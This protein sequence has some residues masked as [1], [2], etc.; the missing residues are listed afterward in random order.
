MKMKMRL[1]T[2][3]ALVMSMVTFLLCGAMLIATTYAWFVHSTANT[4]N[5]ITA[6]YLYVDL[7]MDKQEDG[8]YVSIK[9]GQGDIFNERGNGANWE[10][11]MTKVVYLGIEN[12]ADTSTLA[13]K[14]SFLLEVEGDL[15]DALDYAIVPAAVYEGGLFDEAKQQTQM[16]AWD[17]VIAHPDVFHE[18]MSNSEL[19]P[20]KDKA[21]AVGEINY[22]AL[23]VHMDKNAGDEYQGKEVTIDV[24]VSATQMTSEN[25]AFGNQYD[26]AA[27]T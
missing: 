16:D 15:A 11:G 12:N 3:Q 24:A 21:L 26:E 14:Y 22:F 5:R 8:N 2:H 19:M 20:F 7:L 4:N 27:T 13:L 25:D 6:G 9:N 10:P 23:V 18:N 17:Y 1:K